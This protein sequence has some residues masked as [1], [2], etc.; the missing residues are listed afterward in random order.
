MI[1]NKRGRVAVPL[2]SVVLIANILLS[3]T[4]AYSGTYTNSASNETFLYLFGGLSE[5]NWYTASNALWTIPVIHHILSKR[6]SG[7][8]T[9]MR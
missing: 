4:G 9:F 2:L 8:C 3:I 5:T 7:L 1:E 6:G